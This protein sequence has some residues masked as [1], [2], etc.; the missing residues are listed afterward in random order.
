MRD[1]QYRYYVNVND[2]LTP[3]RVFVVDR[4]EFRRRL[5]AYM[6]LV[7][8]DRVECHYKGR[9]YVWIRSCGWSVI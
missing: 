6:E 8:I 3:S 7:D 9:L 1:L 4:E 5:P 2:E